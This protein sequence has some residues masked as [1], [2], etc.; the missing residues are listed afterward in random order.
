[1]KILIAVDDSEYSREAIQYILDLFNPKMTE[2][3]IVHVLVPTFHSIPPQMSRFYEPE[4]ERREKEMRAVLDSYAAKFRTAGFAVETALENGETR[5]TI[6]DFATQWAADLIVI[7][8]HGHKGL[9]RLLLG[10]VAES[11]VR[12]ATCSVLVVRRHH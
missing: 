7:G 9:E 8:S 11:V 6:I 10:S 3:M 5:S 4:M 12:H 2:I 1:M